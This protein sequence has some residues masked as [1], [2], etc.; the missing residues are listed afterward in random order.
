M[1]DSEKGIKSTY[2][3]KMEQMPPQK[4][5]Q[6]DAF[7]RQKEIF[8]EYFPSG[9]IGPTT[10]EE[11]PEQAVIELEKRSKLLVPPERYKPGN[12][13]KLFV[14][15]HADGTRSFAAVQQKTYGEGGDT[16]EL[17]YLADLDENDAAIG[18]SEIRMNVSNPDGYFKDKPF[19]GF[20]RTF[21]GK[22]QRGFGDRRLRLMNALTRMLY[23]LPIHSDTLLSPEAQKLWEKMEKRGEAVRYKEKGKH[24]RFM[25]K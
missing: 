8:A 21:E 10:L 6:A 4:A 12:F 5:E 20:T 11:I 16:E 1:P 7:H 18:Y 25:L 2:M 3:S 17:T 14:I 9:E 15:R 22:Q 24:D 19:V 23:D 13:E